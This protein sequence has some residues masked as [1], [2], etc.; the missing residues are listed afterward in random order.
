[1]L[2]EVI[3]NIERQGC[4]TKV[5]IAPT[6]LKAPVKLGNPAGEH[7][8]RDQLSLEVRIAGDHLIVD[9]NWTVGDINYV[10]AYG[11]ERTFGHLG[12]VTRDLPVAIDGKSCHVDDILPLNIDP[13]PIDLGHLAQFGQGG[14][15]TA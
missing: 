1:M 6:G 15:K 3:T 13:F 12:D 9:E 8:I 14:I 2:Y 11:I 5:S 10:T 7:Y 4:D